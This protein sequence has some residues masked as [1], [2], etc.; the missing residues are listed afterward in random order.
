MWAG[1]TLTL[2]GLRS[3]FIAVYDP[4]L[5]GQH[6]SASRYVA[7]GKVPLSLSVVWCSCSLP[8]VFPS[9]PF[10]W[11]EARVGVQIRRCVH[12][13]CIPGA[14]RDSA[15]NCGGSAVAVHLPGGGQ[16]L[17]K[18][19]VVQQQV[20]E[21]VRTVVLVAVIGKLRHSCCGAEAIPHGSLVVALRQIAVPAHRFLDKV[22]FM[23]VV[24]VQTVQ[25]AGF[26][27]GYRYCVSLRM[28][29][30]RIPT[31]LTDDLRSSFRI[32]AVCWVRQWL[33]LHASV[34]GGWGI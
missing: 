11:Q 2:R 34:Y 29:Y 20:L 15:E 21:L 9:L 24:L 17:D 25:C 31:F 12:G 19:V 14:G 32:F 30:G 28:A 8:N 4:H 22:V 26:D 3:T 5:C 1:F 6:P 10:W 23:P 27:S 18:P 33:Q 13:F 16:V 7:V